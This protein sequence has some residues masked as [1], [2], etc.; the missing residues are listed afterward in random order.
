MSNKKELL[1]LLENQGAIASSEIQ[2]HLGISQPTA[3]RLISEVEDEVV[4]C[5]KGKSTKYAVARPIGSAPSQQPVWLI[6]PHGFPKR[7][8][9]IS[10]L[11]NSQIYIEGE[12][13][14]EIFTGD[15]NQTLPWYLSNLK[16]QGFLGRLLAYELSQTGVP[17]NPE[18]WNTEQVLIGAIRTNDA[19]GAIIAGGDV[20]R[21]NACN[22]PDDGIEDALDAIT[23]NLSKSVQPGSYAGGE[24]PKFLTSDNH[25]N[26]FLVKF[27][28]PIGTPYGDRWSDL[29]RMECLSGIA[30]NDHGFKAAKNEFIQTK[31]RSYLLSKRFDRTGLGRLH[32]VALGA[33]HHAFV[34]G[35]LV[36]W[37]STC[38][39]LVRQG[40]LDRASAE[41]IHGI[42]Q[43][44]KLIGNSDMHFGNA[45]L[46]VEG[47]S[48]KEIAKG[49]F[50]LT[51][52]YDML[53]MRWKPD[54][55]NGAAP[56]E[57]FEVDFTLADE[58]TRCAAKAF[59]LSVSI[60]DFI[61][62]DL[63]EVALVM[64]EKMG[65]T[66]VQRDRSTFQKD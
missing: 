33:A 15:K 7:L 58:T 12:G 64:S 41:S 55:I 42:F 22:I 29:L 14:S 47:E 4:V 52:V 31:T 32:T 53:P 56:Y 6:D 51:P 37:P 36:N 19:P 21:K 38:D 9:E 45:S 39:A 13:F 10:L 11:A 40:R 35:S 54:Q 25:G 18:S 44:G 27:S 59:W 66:S 50:Q 34:K 60:D 48:L 26:S 49:Q 57:P 1:I 5:G 3:S 17:S 23:L 62:E 28:P 65:C 63:R 30:L 61:S 24:Q 8:G 46:F 2:S 43:F 20:S 16:A